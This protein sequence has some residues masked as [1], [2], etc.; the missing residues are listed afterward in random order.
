MEQ[1]KHFLRRS[2]FRINQARPSS[3]LVPRDH[4]SL[5]S[6]GTPSTKIQ[7][8]QYIQ[9]YCQTKSGKIQLA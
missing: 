2:G 8:T 9:Y 6:L 7:I 3:H 4:I 5:H 1:P